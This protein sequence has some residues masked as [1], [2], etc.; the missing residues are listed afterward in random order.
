LARKVSEIKAMPEGLFKIVL[1]G[2]LI[3]FL[4]AAIMGWASG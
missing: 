4:G 3:L 2:A 1:F